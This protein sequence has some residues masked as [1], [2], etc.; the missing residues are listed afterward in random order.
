M[1]LCLEVMGRVN[2]LNVYQ[3][4]YLDSKRRMSS[5]PHYESATMMAMKC[6]QQYDNTFEV[7]IPPRGGTTKRST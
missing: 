3:A 7:L 1:W 4:T 5:H 2:A 6:I